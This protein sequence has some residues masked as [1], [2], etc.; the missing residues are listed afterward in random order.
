MKFSEVLEDTTTGDIAPSIGDGFGKHRKR[1]RLCEKCQAE[2]NESPVGSVGRT[3]AKSA[4]EHLSPELKK[5]FKKLLKAVGGKTVMRYLLANA[6][7]KEASKNEY[8][9]QDML[10]ELL[11][12]SHID[13]NSF[14]ELG[15]MSNNAGLVVKYKN[16][17]YQL[18]I[19]ED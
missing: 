4:L 17:K 12:K 3:D 7:L 19:V 9:F 18:T 11:D 10:V 6:P 16:K 5:E 14:E 8:N 15:L 2:I 1:K 13:V